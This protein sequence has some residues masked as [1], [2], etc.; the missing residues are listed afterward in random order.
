MFDKIIRCKYLRFHVIYWA[1]T[2]EL[3]LLQWGKSLARFL[4]WFQGIRPRVT[5][6][7]FFL[8]EDEV[9]HAAERQP[10]LHDLSLCRIVRY[11]AEVQDSGRLT[12]LGGIQFHLRNKHKGFYISQLLIDWWTHSVWWFFTTT[13]SQ[14]RIAF[15]WSA[16][17]WM[18]GHWNW[19]GHMT[20][21]TSLVFTCK[22]IC[23][24]M[25]LKTAYIFLKTEY[26]LRCF[27]EYSFYLV[28]ATTHHSCNS[29]HNCWADEIGLNLSTHNDHRTWPHPVRTHTRDPR[30]F[31]D[32]FV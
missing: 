30:V 11:T 12:G 13:K 9:G 15:F 4:Q 16:W 26:N 19:S 27:F 22:N 5:Y 32:K 24:R 21:T 25:C 10:E 1:S 8:G 20:F 18:I 14:I 29:W 7:V 6:L 3:L 31:T 2:Q 28:N 17:Q 23:L